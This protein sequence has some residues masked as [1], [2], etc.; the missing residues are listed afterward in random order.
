MSKKEVSVFSMPDEIAK[1]KK[2]FLDPSTN[3]VFDEKWEYGKTYLDENMNYIVFT[4]RIYIADEMV[5]TIPYMSSSFGTMY[6]DN[7]GSG[8]DW[9][10]IYQ[11]F[12][13]DIFPKILQQAPLANRV[14]TEAQDQRLL[15][16]KDINGTVIKHAFCNY[17]DDEWR[18]VVVG[19]DGQKKQKTVTV[20]LHVPP[21]PQM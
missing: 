10:K 9:N 13:H 5:G 6:H 16:V 17:V 8:L 20:T 3:I 18:V 21:P 4:A 15:L 12:H 11:L 14:E 1:L 19:T 7:S 2:I